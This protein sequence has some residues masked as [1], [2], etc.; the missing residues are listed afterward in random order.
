VVVKSAYLLK[1]GMH[2]EKKDMQCDDRSFL[3]VDFYRCFGGIRVDIFLVLY[4]S[5]WRDFGGFG[6]Q[7]KQCME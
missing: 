4:K 7:Q 6:R 2:N 5:C 1:G 3:S